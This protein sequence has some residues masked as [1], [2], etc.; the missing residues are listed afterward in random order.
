MVFVLFKVFTVPSICLVLEL[1]LPL[2]L[3]GLHSGLVVDLGYSSCRVLPTFAGVPVL[4]ALSDAPCGTKD[5][6]QAIKE[7]L[8]TPTAGNEGKILEKLEDE[9]VLEDVL[10]CACYVTC[11]FPKDGEHKAASL[12]T[13]KDAEVRLVGD[14]R[15]VKVPAACRHSVTEV[16]FQRSA[17]SYHSCSCDTIPEAVVRTL[18]LCPMDI[19]AQ[20]VQNVVICGGAAMLRGLL[21]RLAQEMQKSLK[22]HKALAA[23]ASKLQITPLDFA[24]ICASWTGGAIFGSLEGIP[25]YSAEDFKK[26][27]PLPD[28]LRNGF[29]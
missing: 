22:Q 26:G 4:S 7:A 18:E 5:V 13:D 17:E 11:D 3:S 20:L 23:L 19:R 8:K 15:A 10:V 14:D 25:E 2:Y 16:F 24:P 9:A 12:K 21:P 27:E 28:W 29:V 6:L 1:V